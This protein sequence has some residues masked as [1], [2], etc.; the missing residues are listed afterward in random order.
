[1]SLTLLRP[2]DAAQHS[3]ST[4]VEIIQQQQFITPNW[5]LADLEPRIDLLQAQFLDFL[6]GEEGVSDYMSSFGVFGG[7]L[8]SL[9]GSFDILETWPRIH[10]YALKIHSLDYNRADIHELA[11]RVRAMLI[12]YTLLRDHQSLIPVIAAAMPSTYK[13]AKTAARVLR[14]EMREVV[15]GVTKLVF[16]WISPR[17]ES[18]GEMQDYFLSKKTK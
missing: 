3:K 17:F 6:N 7:S 14:A 4:S 18:V 11:R 13:D 8:E 15:D 5:T 1:M 12:A 10:Q 2:S 9:N 16:S